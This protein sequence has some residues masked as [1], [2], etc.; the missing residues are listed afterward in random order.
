VLAGLLQRTRKGA[1]VTSVNDAE[2]V[3]KCAEGLAAL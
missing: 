3:G 2:S 1:Y